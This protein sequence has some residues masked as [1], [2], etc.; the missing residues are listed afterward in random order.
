MVTGIGIAIAIVMVVLT[1]FAMI[2]IHKA[3]QESAKKD[4]FNKC[5]I[6]NFARDLKEA[7]VRALSSLAF[8]RDREAIQSITKKFI[9]IQELNPTDTNVDWLEK[10]DILNRLTV[11]LDEVMDSMDKT[12]ARVEEARK[13]GPGLLDILPGIIKNVESRRNFTKRPAEARILLERAKGRLAEAAKM[14]EANEDLDWLKIYALLIMVSHDTEAAINCTNN[15][16]NIEFGDTGGDTTIPL[17]ATQDNQE[18]PVQEIIEAPVELEAPVESCN[19]DNS[20]YGGG[21]SDSGGGS[22]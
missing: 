4:L 10:A 3:A 21:S 13:Y 5:G 15:N 11:W 6:A 18:Q 16:N 19:S 1:I 7:R 22:D 2:Q 20:S 14:A 8:E 17:E 9:L 12:S